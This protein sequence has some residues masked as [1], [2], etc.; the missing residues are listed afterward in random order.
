M[1]IAAFF[2]TVA[3]EMF[4]AE[5]L[6]AE[7]LAAETLAAEKLAADA[8][9]AE[10]ALAAQ[11]LAATQQAAQA[12]IMEVGGATA[13]PLT[14]TPEAVQ[15]A[16][17]NSG[18]PPP[19]PPASPAPN[20]FDNSAIETTKAA[21]NVVTS[22]IANLQPTP[23]FEGITSGP[24]GASPGFF[25]PSAAPG[26]GPMQYQLNAPTGGQ[27]MR[28][29]SSLESMVAPTTPMTSVLP[30]PSGLEAGFD[31]ALKFAEKNPFT[32]MTL[33]YTGANALGLMNPSG[34]TFNQEKYDG[35][36]S[37]Y[38]LSP[39]FQAGNANPADFQYRPRYA[40]GG[41][42]MGAPAY[43]IPVGYD[44][45]GPVAL[46]LPS[47]TM[48]SSDAFQVSGQPQD[49]SQ[50]AAADAYNDILRNRVIAD[51]QRG[52]VGD[53]MY[54]VADARQLE[55]TANSTVRG[56]DPTLAKR[57][58]FNRSNEGEYA[59]PG[60]GDL[61]QFAGGNDIGGGMG[62]GSLGKYYD[63]MSASAYA[64]GGKTDDPA[65]VPMGSNRLSPID[66]A[67]NI[68]LDTGLLTGDVTL[69][70]YGQ[71]L[72]LGTSLASL[73]TGARNALA[74][75]SDV[76]RYGVAG[77]GD[78]GQ[79]A[80]SFDP[81]NVPMGSN[82]FSPAEIAQMAAYDTAIM[83]GTAPIMP[84]NKS[85]VIQNLRGASD[86][87][88]Y[89]VPGYGDLGQFAGGF[90]NSMGMGG[91]GGKYFDDQSMAT[92]AMAKGG[93]LSESIESYQK[94]LAGKPQA[95]PSRPAD[96]GIY[97]DQ[98]PDTR[99]QDALTAAQIRQSKV[100][101]RAYVSPPAA[102]RPTPMGQ[103][104]MASVKPRK[105]GS[106]DVEAASGGIMQSSLG[107]YAAG[108]NPRL[109][110]GPGDG[111]SDNIPATIN[112][113]QPARL[114]DGEFVIPADVVS[115]LGNGSTEAGAKQLHAMMDKVRKAR[116]GNPKQG[117]Q[118]NARKY[119]PK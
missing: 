99:Y 65:T 56:F 80:G 113:R 114:A 9:I 10:Q 12:G 69:D 94:M 2:A 47:R 50:F 18:M 91:G 66:Q 13:N 95:A 19:A 96:V 64:K 41:G 30:P 46:P 49:A 37:K 1:P 48:R 58:L 15:N 33:A 118:I 54:G 98:D 112:R 63:D 7:A 116:T 52:R 11:Q 57:E 83:Q 24:Q 89:G 21:S 28:L 62:G 100:N 93:S 104:Q 40:T 61:G 92:M 75:D 34:A 74:A 16:A 36:L 55:T 72:P 97:Y 23:G 42:I 38:K 102:K 108:G 87:G 81:A 39:N 20:L 76:G 115:H 90:G 4:A 22:P 68:K 119:M 79:F 109:L 29:G 101:Q 35:P 111:M 84:R 6:G 8:I 26:Q 5:V 32:A 25:N 103:L 110:K 59:V 78:L 70:N 43:D 17:M 107:G 105:Q 60:Y 71:P 51:T 106:D 27:G 86:A 53:S 73:Q 67:S 85:G 88:A 82:K 117:K 14:L 44:E 45:G 3:P 31:K 77:I